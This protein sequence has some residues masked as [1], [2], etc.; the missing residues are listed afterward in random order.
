MCIKSSHVYLKLTEFYVNYIN[1]SGKKRKL[2]ENN[3]IFLLKK[4]H[5]FKLYDVIYS[6]WLLIR[7]FLSLIFSNLIIM[8][9]SMV[10]F[11]FLLLVVYWIFGLVFIVFINIREVFAKISLGI[12]SATFPFPILAFITCMLGCLLLSH[13]SLRF[14]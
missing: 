8:C 13:N 5:V 4:K 3:S 11:V 9:I 14:C 6:L 12:S 7:V 2:K 1:K 10:F